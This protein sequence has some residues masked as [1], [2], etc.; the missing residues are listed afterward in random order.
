[1]KSPKM[2][3]PG[4]GGVVRWWHHIVSHGPVLFSKHG[5][6]GDPILPRSGV[7]HKRERIGPDKPSKI[8]PHPRE[9]WR[10][11]TASRGCRR[12]LVEPLSAVMRGRDQFRV[13]LSESRLRIEGE[14]EIYERDADSGCK[15]LS[16]SE[17]DGNG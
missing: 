16:M 11:W 1:M 5:S 12:V 15:M 8:R 2:T 6:A 13:R 17:R 4:N 14:N 7:N 3:A 10:E 9:A